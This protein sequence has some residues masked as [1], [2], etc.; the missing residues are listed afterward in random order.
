LVSDH[1]TSRIVWGTTG[2]DAAA[3]GRFFDELPDGA[4]DDLAAI[5]MDLGPAYAKTARERAPH[6]TLCFDPLRVVK[7]AADALDKVRR[8]VWQSAR[9]LPDAKIA[10]KYKGA[11][12]PTAIPHLSRPTSMSGAAFMAIVVHAAEGTFG[13]LAGAVGSWARRRPS[14]SGSIQRCGSSWRS[15]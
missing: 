6:A 1:A 9:R 2:K 15:A 7:L 11:Q 13:L 4:A 8:Q 5:S 14:W 12:T 10:K 3:F